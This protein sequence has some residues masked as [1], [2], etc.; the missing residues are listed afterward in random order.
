M[1]LKANL[2]WTWPC[3]SPTIDVRLELQ[4][5]R[6]CAKKQVAQLQSC[7]NTNASAYPGKSG[8]GT[9]IPHLKHS[10]LQAYHKLNCAA[11]SCRCVE[12][13]FCQH[14]SMEPS[15]PVFLKMWSDLQDTS[16][17]GLTQNAATGTRMLSQ[18]NGLVQDMP[19][20]VR[21]HWFKKRS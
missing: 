11:K 16:G 6:Q 17:P 4:R 2:S 20:E 10:T 14:E 18:I 15:L 9:T 8:I 1:M 12:L 7:A 19:R 5:A 3:S 21:K 13:T